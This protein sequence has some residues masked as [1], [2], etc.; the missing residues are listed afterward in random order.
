MLLIQDLTFM[1][2]NSRHEVNSRYIILNYTV[3][4]SKKLCLN[5]FDLSGLKV[6]SSPCANLSETF[7]Y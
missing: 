5:Q 4:L 6:L 1:K 2:E 7:I 3:L